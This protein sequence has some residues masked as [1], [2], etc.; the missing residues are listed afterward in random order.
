VTNLFSQRFGTGSPRVLFLHGLGSAGPVWWRIAEALAAAGYPSITPDLRGHGESPLADGYSL[1]GYA[2]D[3]VSSQPGPW[4]LVI[5]HSLGGAV[6]VRAAVID[7]GFAAGYLLIDPAIDLDT[8]TVESLRSDLVAE[9]EH[10]PTV[11]QLIEDHPAWTQEDAVRKRA[12]VLATSPAVM[13][14]TFDDNPEWNV[15]QALAG[16]KTPVHILGADIDPLY[17]KTDYDRH[18]HSDSTLTFEVVPN[19]GH[20]I[21]RDDPETVIARARAML[22]GP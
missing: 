11:A 1:D 14:G 20:S 7:P 4:D 19:T 5:G 21:H 13:S 9:A 10:P 17:T 6:A 18:A 12:A 15:G 2:G 22:V 8:I 3:V 16:V